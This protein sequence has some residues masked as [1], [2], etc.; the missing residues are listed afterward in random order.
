MVAAN[1]VQARAANSRV[2]PR[3]IPNSASVKVRPQNARPSPIVIGIASNLLDAGLPRL[4]YRN[5]FGK[6]REILRATS[7]M[8]KLQGRPGKPACRQDCLP[9]MADESQ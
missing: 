9:H 5:H 2:I 6:S 7:K 1:S 4:R 3:I 8:Y